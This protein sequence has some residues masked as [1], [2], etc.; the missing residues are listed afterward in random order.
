MNHSLLFIFCLL[1]FNITTIETHTSMKDTL[2]E[3]ALKELLE[4]LKAQ[5]QWIKVHAAEYLLWMGHSKEVKKAFM[6]ENELYNTE[7]KYRIGIW[8]VLTEAETSPDQKIQ[9]INKIFDAFQ[10]INGIDRLHAA[11]TLA[12]LKLSPLP[13]YPEATKNALTSGNRILYGY[14]LWATAYASDSALSNNRQEF[15]NL[16]VSDSNEVI[17]KISAFVLR[18]LGGLT[19]NQWIYLSKK[20]LSEPAESGLRNSLL[21][22]AFVTLPEG[23]DESGLF[24]KIREEV[25]KDYKLFAVEKQIELALSLAEKGTVADLPVLQTF[26]NN[27]DI[28]DKYEPNSSEAADV[29][30]AAAFAIL[31]I[32]RSSN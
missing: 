31:K 23:A 4:T 22:T 20:A 12:K 5:P 14:A 9:W 15:L 27:E 21:N 8:R 26:L 17:R 3:K 11:E 18:K 29:R 2:E 19:K 1:S 6:Q 28:L 13:K 7:P 30:A 25:F 10:D 32:K 24:Q 16:A